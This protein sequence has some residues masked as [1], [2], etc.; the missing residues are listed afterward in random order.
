MHPLQAIQKIPIQELWKESYI[1]LR[2]IEV[3]VSNFIAEDPYR[4]I[5]NFFIIVALVMLLVLAHRRIIRGTVNV[6]AALAST[7]R[8]VAIEQQSNLLVCRNTLFMF[9]TICSSFVFANIAYATK[10]MGYTYTVPVK[11]AGILGFI[12]SYFLVRRIIL[13]FLAWLNRNKV[14]NLAD[15]L[16]HTYACLWYMA[17]LCSFIVIK[18]IP[19]A[20][21]G[22]MRYCMIF[23]LLAIYIPYFF[24]L[25]KIFIPK[26][27]SHF[28]YIL[29]L[30]T[31]EILPIAVLLH[32]NFS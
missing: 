29:Y 2:E 11:F 8:L 31:L 12:L 24:A 1:A 27:V 15:K 7:K 19:S 32:L 26:G 4:D 17:V 5:T 6:L 28:F 14:F 13:R 21:M 16:A 9:L 22:T 23:S 18:A 30:C 10:I 25:Y 3:P 20:P